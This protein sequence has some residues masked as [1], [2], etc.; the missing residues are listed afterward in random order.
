MKIL[1]AYAASPYGFNES[2]KRFYYKEFLPCIE[3]AGF[4]ILDP[5][6]PPL[7]LEQRLNQALGMDIGE[8]Q[9]RAL[10][11]VNFDMGAFNHS[12]ISA[13]DIVVAGLDGTDVD[14]GTASEVGAAAVMLKMIEGYRDD[15]R[16]AGDNIGSVVNLQVEYWIKKQYGIIS[17]SLN[18]L[19]SR[20]CMRAAQAA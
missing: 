11:K 17:K 7:E 18:A 3:S 1:K 6:R 14:S 15:F 10:S 12:S 8:G 9:A 13:C 4:E 2:G 19:K 20:L 16:S 5:W